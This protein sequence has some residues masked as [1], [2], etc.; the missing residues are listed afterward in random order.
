M[1]I[2]LIGSTGFFGSRIL[3]EAQRRS[4]L[5]TS[6]LH[7]EADVL[8][9]RQMAPMISGN[10]V[11]VSAFRSRLK[12]ELAADAARSLL[13]AVTEARVGRLIIVGGAGSLEASPGLLLID[14]PEFPVAYAA[15]A[16]AQIEALGVLRAESHVEWTYLSPAAE[17]VSGERTGA[18]RLGADILL[19][20]ASGNSVIS[21]EDC[22]FALMDEVEHPQHS[23]RRFTIAY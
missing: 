1:K 12:P 21:V 17:V 2:A 14:T 15:D 23:R 5:V 18:F 4:L 3:A 6:I 10:D 16:R 13:A 20:D 7:S 11:V 8:S 22:A 9:P 19:R